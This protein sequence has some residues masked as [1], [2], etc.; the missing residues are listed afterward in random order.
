MI[1]NLFK[2]KLVLIKQNSSRI[3]DIKASVQDKIYITDIG[4]DIVVGDILE[5]INPAGIKNYL[6]V[7][8][9]TYHSHHRLG[10]IEVE[11]IKTENIPSIYLD[12]NIISR[13][14][15]SNSTKVEIKAL[16]EISIQYSQNKVKLFTSIKAKEELEKINDENRKGMILFFYNLIRNIPY[17]N[18]MLHKGSFGDDMFFGDIVLSGWSEEGQILK[19]LKKFFDIDDAEHI[20]QAEKSQ[21]DYFLTLDKKT[22]LNRIK[23]KPKQFQ[24]IGLNIKIVSPIE[25]I[26]ILNIKNN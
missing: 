26:D 7:M 25:L 2:D 14:I 9:V 15:D 5:Y 13:R 19:K 3:E 8:K 10:H 6:K 11:Y 22:I 1:S 20:F 21:I 24:D 4:I 12:T 16:E 18:Y 17:S 23:N